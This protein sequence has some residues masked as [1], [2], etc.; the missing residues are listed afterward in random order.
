MLD[1]LT[2]ALR[3]VY[4]RPGFS[5]VAVLTLAF[6]IAVNASLFALV[7]AF[8]LQPLH[9][10]DPQELVMIMQRSEIINVRYGHSFPDYLDYRASASTL[11]DVAAYMPTPVHLSTAGQVPERTWVEVVSPNYFALAGVTAA[12][13]ELLEPGVG[14]SR[15]A[16][17]T[18][19]LSY[20]YWQRRF[21]GNPGIVGQPVTLNGRTFTVI[22][23]APPA[24]TGLSW[25]MAVSAWVPSGAIGTLMSGGDDLRDSRG[26]PPGG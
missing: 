24:F 20:K 9:A 11:S 25:A 4:K 26:A 10:K 8:F 17:P 1:D 13:G 21:G 18:A 12:F 16:A 19:V 15:G 14:E 3:S 23:V 6:G 22:G 2:Q 5:A 7:N